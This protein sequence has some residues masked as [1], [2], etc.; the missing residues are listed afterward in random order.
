MSKAKKIFFGVWAA[1]TII[2][3]LFGWVQSTRLRR[4]V[5]TRDQIRYGSVVALLG[6]SQRL[7]DSAAGQ[8]NK[9]TADT[10]VAA[11]LALL[12][13]A[14]SEAEPPTSATLDDEVA[15]VQS[16]R[17]DMMQGQPVSDRLRKEATSIR[18]IIRG[19]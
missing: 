6:Q 18:D 1:V 7:L 2:L 15:R 17:R 13:E 14:A 8:P 9:N 5:L 11:A 10:S 12:H 16:V 19:L 4:A 3:V